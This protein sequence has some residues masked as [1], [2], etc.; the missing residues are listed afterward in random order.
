MQS[1]AYVQT[2]QTK[3]DELRI[4]KLKLPVA[5]ALVGGSRSIRPAARETETLALAS[6]SS[7]GAIHETVTLKASL[8]VL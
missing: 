3:D 1:H 2:A 7:S 6:T 4:T 8:V 5:L